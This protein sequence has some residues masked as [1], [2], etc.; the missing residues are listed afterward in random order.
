MQVMI[1]YSN[2]EL[3]K[4]KQWFPKLNYY[5][6]DN[7]IIG[8][9][10]ISPCRYQKVEIDTKLSE[11]QIKPC[12]INC[13]D[14]I[15]GDFLIQLE[16]NNRDGQGYPKVYEISEKI[17]NL[18]KELGKPIIDL[19][20]YPKDKRCCL[21]IKIELRHTLS[22]FILYDVYPYFVWQA[23][24]SQYKKVPPCG[25]YSH[26]KEG[27]KEAIQ[28]YEKTMTS[29]KKKR[30]NEQCLCNSGQKYKNCC[31][32]KDKVKRHNL[33]IA[34]TRLHKMEKYEKSHIKKNKQ[35][36]KIKI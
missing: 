10:I 22:E 14:R 18:A 33:S 30:R 11:W 15:V 28:D 16:F 27:L 29:V 34:K 23:Y 9:F 17:E 31:L 12:D 24:Y 8:N 7:K 5:E 35:I 25:E 19:H 21:G 26:G 36:K 3:K 20:L 32:E 4:I 6:G 1:K 2:E 13:N